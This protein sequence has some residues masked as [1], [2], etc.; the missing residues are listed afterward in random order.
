MYFRLMDAAHLA[1]IKSGVHTRMTNNIIMLANMQ[2]MLLPG[3]HLIS[4]PPPGHYSLGNFV[5]LGHYSLV[6]HVPP[7][8]ILVC[9][10][11]QHNA[12]P[13]LMVPVLFL[14]FCGFCFKTYMY[15]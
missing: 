10:H 3:D 1:G 6:N 5:S 9:I 4:A 8:I 11:Y 13:I 7:S 15:M 12:R 14:G 2:V